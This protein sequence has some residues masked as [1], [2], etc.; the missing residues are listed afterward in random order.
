L[1]TTVGEVVVLGVGPTGAGDDGDSAGEATEPVVDGGIGVVV[2]VG[3]SDDVVAVA[4]ESTV[5]AKEF[6]P[7]AAS[8]ASTVCAGHDCLASFVVPG[9]MPDVRMIVAPTIRVDT[10]IAQCGRRIRSIAP[11][12]RSLR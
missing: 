3:D 7:L 9:E 4:T 5:D 11:A 2:V 12:F 1:T 8:L 10:T 6:A